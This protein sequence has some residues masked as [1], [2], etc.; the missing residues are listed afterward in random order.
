MDAGVAELPQTPR[1]LSPSAPVGAPPPLHLITTRTSMR[2]LARPT[3]VF[4]TPQAASGAMSPASPGSMAGYASARGSLMW[5]PGSEA[6]S[7]RHDDAGV[8]ST[9]HMSVFRDAYEDL[10]LSPVRSTL[11]LRAMD[12]RGTRSP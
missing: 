12:M 11:D 3:S 4:E 10:P 7:H 1:A 8:S 6:T 2:P 9:G 5:S